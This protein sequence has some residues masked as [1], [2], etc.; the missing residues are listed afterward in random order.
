[1][2]DRVVAKDR[3]ELPEPSGVTRHLDR[4]RVD[5]DPD[6]ARLRESSQTRRRVERDLGKLHRLV[7]DLHVTGVRARKEQEVVDEGVQPANLRVHVV[8]RVAHLSHPPL[9][10]TPE[11]LEAAADDRERRPELVAGVGGELALTPERVA[12]GHERTLRVEPANAQG[13]GQDEEATEPK[14]REEDVERPHLR[15]ALADDL[16]DV[17]TVRAVER[18]REDANRR[19]GQRRLD[20]PPLPGPGG[21]QARWLRER[22]GD[23]DHGRRV[24]RAYHEGER[25]RRRPEKVEP[26][27]GRCAH[28]DGGNRHDRR[29]GFNLEG[30]AVEPRASLELLDPPAGQGVGDGSVEGRAERHEDDE[31]RPTAPGQ[32]PPADPSDER[33]VARLAG[34][35]HPGSAI[36][37][38]TPRTV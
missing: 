9:A 33:G 7:D 6:A 15:R 22:Q 21:G 3:H 1:M 23:A 8:E 14:D 11:V 26:R 25:T 35:R 17:P 12:D 2:S 16:H 5:L 32:Q 19:T 13:H 24:L 36:R 30:G 18:H 37:Y 27:V 29:I 38:P 10:V 20:D 31:R 4:H 34:P 28:D